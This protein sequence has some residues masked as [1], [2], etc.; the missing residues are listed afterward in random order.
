MVPSWL[1]ARK[2]TR[3]FRSIKPKLPKLMPLCACSD[4][5]NVAVRAGGTLILLSIAI[6][7]LGRSAAISNSDLTYQHMLMVLLM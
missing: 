2:H 3:G 6:N 1:V 7:I 5:L 4:I